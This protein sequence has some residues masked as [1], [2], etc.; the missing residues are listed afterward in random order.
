MSAFPSP[1]VGEGGS[2]RGAETD[3]GCWQD[4][5]RFVSSNTPHPSPSATPSPTRGEGKALRALATL[6]FAIFFL[7]L[8]ALAAHAGMNIQEVKSDKGITAWLVEDHTVPIIAIRFVFDGGTAQDPAGKEGLANL[9][10]GL[11]DEGAG[12]LDSDA[13]QVKLDDAGA[14]MS[15][16][17]QRDGIYG[18]MRMLSEQ[19]DAAFDLLTLAVNKPRFDQAPLDRVRAQVLAG[20]VA[21]ERDPNAIAQRKWLRAIY[22]EHPYSRPDE[23]TRESIAAI[24]PADLGAFHRASFARDGLHVA[25]VGDIDAA[26]L[27]RKL[28]QL[29]GDLPQ[30]QALAAIADTQP[31]LGQQVEVDYDLPQTS[32]QFAYPGVKRSAPDFFAAVLMNEILG[33]GTFT[34]RLYDEVREKR[35]LAY[36][37]DSNLVDHQHSNALIITTATRSDRAS[38]TLAIVRD[39]VKTLAEQGPTEAELD[40]A[41]KYMIGAYAIN[42][43]DS[44]GSIAATLVELQLD[45][46][47]IDYLQRRAGLINAVTLDDV[48]AAAKKLLSPAPAI[49]VVGP[50]LAKAAGGGKG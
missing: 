35:G 7:I 47:G 9:M 32:L 16:E 4:R 19:K 22:G 33:G 38:E 49:M 37:V 36:G 13:F 46:L 23:G 25:V 1:L 12:D 11:F 14:E 27:K 18:S 20:I 26:S 17:P 5:P 31:K 10:T 48:K 50:P 30:R 40:A 8:P 6:C 39:V 28:D 44:S 2:A 45:R 42:N 43:L 24:A 34:S 41:K 15:F 3:E 21:N 29:F